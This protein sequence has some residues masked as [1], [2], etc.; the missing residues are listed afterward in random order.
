MEIKSKISGNVLICYVQGELDHHTADEFRN[1]IDYNLEN[2]AV[3]H[4]V[5]DLSRLEFMDSSGI[6]A[7][8]GRYK[9]VSSLGGKTAVANVNNQVGR[10]LKV[11][12]IYDIITSYRNPEQALKELYEE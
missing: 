8:I 5:L 6:G 2:N 3:K 11:S 12:G 10:L 7:L 1:Y 9:K 4:L